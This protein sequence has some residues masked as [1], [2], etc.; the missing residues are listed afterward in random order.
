MNAW[1]WTAKR[2]LNQVGWMGISGISLLI[3]SATFY[4]SAVVPDRTRT[5]ELKQETASLRQRAQMSLAQG[6]ISTSN[7]TE[8]QLKTFYKFFPATTEKVNVLG[9]IYSAAEHQNLLLETGEYRYL[10]DQT[11]TLSRYQVTLPIKGSYL[12]IRNFVDEILTEVPSTSVD[13]ISFKRETVNS[14]VLDARIKLTL[15][16]GGH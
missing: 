4:F 8:T 9:K 14:P 5:A 1:N 6:G 10:P 2:W 11:N 16:F 7:N 13:D 3:F 12:Q 15:F